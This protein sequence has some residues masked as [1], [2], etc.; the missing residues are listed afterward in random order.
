[1]IEKE[2]TLMWRE[3]RERVKA[4]RAEM[5]SKADTEGWT[6]HSNYHYSRM[7]AGKRF[8]WWPSGGKGMYDGRM[9]YGHREVNSRVAKL[10]AQET[11]HD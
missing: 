3:N 1:M 6:K 11:S 2:S 5:L 10:I 8:D 7:F 4:H 9:I